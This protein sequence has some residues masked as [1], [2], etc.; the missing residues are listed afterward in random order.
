MSRDVNPFDA[1]I[2]S[3][4]RVHRALPLSL[5]FVEQEAETSRYPVIPGMNLFL[6]SA[7]VV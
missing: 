2:I 1:I 4:L 5:S 6:S 3:Y 7:V